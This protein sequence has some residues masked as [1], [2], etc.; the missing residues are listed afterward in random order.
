MLDDVAVVLVFMEASVEAFMAIS[1][2]GW[3][4]VAILRIPNWRINR[5]L[6]QYLSR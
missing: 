5:F 4:G 2:G 3:D 1:K 6:W